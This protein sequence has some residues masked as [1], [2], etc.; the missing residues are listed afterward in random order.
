LFPFDNHDPNQ[1]SVIGMAIGS[2]AAMR[3]ANANLDRLEERLDREARAATSVLPSKTN[4][5]N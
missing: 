3:G 1:P 4:S 2:T 5:V